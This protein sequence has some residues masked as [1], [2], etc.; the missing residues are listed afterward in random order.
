M[1]IKQQNKNILGFSLIEL[2]V[3]I[4]IIGVLSAVLVANFMGMRER[5]RDAQKIQD[6]GAIKNALRL[7]YNDNQSYPVDFRTIAPTYISS[8]PDAVYVY[9]P[10]PLTYDSFT[11]TVQLEAGAGDEDIESQAKCNTG[12]NDDKIFAV[13]AN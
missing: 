10:D 9:N 1:L 2:L 8:I 4:S 3:V 11:L 12:T 5:A 7:Y 13:C 6:L